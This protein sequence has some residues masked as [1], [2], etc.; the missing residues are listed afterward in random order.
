V[1][2]AA[3]FLASPWKRVVAGAVDFFPYLLLFIVAMA[4][5]RNL[6]GGPR[7]PQVGPMYSPSDAEFRLPGGRK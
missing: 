4:A 3:P 2:N 7:I 5:V 1:P 6:L